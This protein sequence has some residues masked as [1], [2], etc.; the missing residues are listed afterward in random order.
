MCRIN[1]AGL[2][3]VTWLQDDTVGMLLLLQV[4][5]CSNLML[6]SEVKMQTKIVVRLEELL[7][8]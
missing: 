3:A 2:A 6:E 5:Y 4:N 7:L 1:Q 8:L